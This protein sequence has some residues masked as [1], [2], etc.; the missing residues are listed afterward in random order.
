[1]S[2]WYN[3]FTESAGLKRDEGLFS[4]ADKVFYILDSFVNRK[5]LAADC[6]ELRKRAEILSVEKK[7]DQLVLAYFCLEKFIVENKPLIT[8][9]QINVSDLRRYISREVPLKEVFLRLRVPFLESTEQ[10]VSIF[11]I[12]SEETVK[13][14]KK[15][16]GGD[17]LETILSAIVEKDKFFNKISLNGDLINLELE[18]NIEANILGNQEAVYHLRNLFGVLIDEVSDKFGKSTADK[19][20]KNSFNSF[21][22]AYPLEFVQKFLDISPPGF[23][24][25]EKMS[26][27]ARE[28]LQKRLMETLA[29]EKRKSD[30]AKSLAEKLQETILELNSNKA[31]VL[32]LLEDIGDEKNKIEK[33]VEKRT[34]ELRSEQLILRST[35]DSLPVA[36][37]LISRDFLLIENNSLLSRIFPDKKIVGFT[38]MEKIFGNSFP[39]KEKCRLVLDRMEAE[40]FDNVAVNNKFFKIYLQPIES[41]HV[42]EK[43]GLLGLIEDITE[44]KTLERSKDEFFSIASH[45]LRTPLTAIMGNTSMILEFFAAELPS[46]EVRQMVEDIHEASTRLLT[47]VSDFLDVSRLEQ[48]K[49]IF[50]LEKLDLSELSKEVIRDFASAAKLRGLSLEIGGMLHDSFVIG[51]KD[52]VKQI[53][54]NLMSNAINYTPKGVISIS[55]K[56]DDIDTV[57]FYIKDSGIG[58]SDENK[59]LLFRKFQQAQEKILTRDVSRS[60]GLGLY[61]S[62][63]LAEAMGGN[64]D[65]VK[66]IKGEGSIFRLVLPAKM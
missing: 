42:G 59:V 45:E 16:I 8:K 24:N 41:S 44:S 22:A 25:D 33:E 23:L 19:L 51:D 27:L 66:S 14:L 37:F 48:G 58:I 49:I 17:N 20:V 62:R 54:S 32:N 64:V 57:S 31:A 60:T 6:F 38:D 39:I 52:K 55:V 63:L 26:L 13:Y 3:I 47:I 18:K 5:D 35:I 40:V 61:I 15:N 2:H 36:Y 10:M 28:E 56:K 21:R 4:G 1:M 46:Q 7:I 50:K 30:E 9:K 65:L 34:E 11:T 43:I 12:A 53:L 29:E